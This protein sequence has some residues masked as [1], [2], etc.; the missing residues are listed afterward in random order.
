MLKTLELAR[1]V[2]E[3]RVAP[4]LQK[5]GYSLMPV[6]QKNP[7][8]VEWKLGEEGSLR[9]KLLISRNCCGLLFFGGISRPML[10]FGKKPITALDILRKLKYAVE[11]EIVWQC[12]QQL[13]KLFATTNAIIFYPQAR[14]LEWEVRGRRFY[15][16][17]FSI[18]LQKETWRWEGAVY[19]LK[20]IGVP[21][22]EKGFP[23]Q[24]TPTDKEP[25]PEAALLEVA[26][27]SI[28]EA[29]L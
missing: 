19:P 28:A 1:Q 25:N 21:D 9:I 22:Y 5:W 18:S 29:L 16:C 10:E 20:N 26:K 3:A 13:A 8:E 7:F 12:R 2:F 24:L 17:S 4:V 23:F 6:E 11:S 14:L 15:T 27:L